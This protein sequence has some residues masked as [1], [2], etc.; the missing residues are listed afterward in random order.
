MLFYFEGQRSVAEVVF[1]FP[2]PGRRY[3][4]RPIVCILAR[5]EDGGVKGASVWCPSREKH[6]KLLHEVLKPETELQRAGLFSFSDRK[7]VYCCCCWEFA[8]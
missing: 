4:L 1:V 6:P 7:R 5:V 3:D 8:R 2:G